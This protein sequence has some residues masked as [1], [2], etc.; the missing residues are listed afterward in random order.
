MRINPKYKE[1]QVAKVKV[2][3]KGRESLAPKSVRL[4]QTDGLSRRELTSSEDCPIA[5]KA[6][7]SAG[8][9]IESA[10]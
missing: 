6:Q 7:S 5:P 8:T 1:N 9:R 10:G 2:R 3:Y 4:W